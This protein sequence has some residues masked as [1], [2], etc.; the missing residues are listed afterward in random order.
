MKLRN[1]GALLLL[2]MIWGISF[3]LIR[4]AAPELGPLTLVNAR[5]LIASSVLLLYAV[6]LR[7]ARPQLRA[8]WKAYLILGALN[9]AL[10]L[11]LEAIAVVH[12]SASLA[13]MLVTTTPLFTALAAALWLGERLTLPKLIGL[14]L[15]LVGVGILVGWSPLPLSLTVG[16]AVGASLLSALFYA[17]AGI[18]AKVAFRKTPALS[19]A[20]GQAL[21]AGVVMLPLT[22]AAPPSTFPTL[23]A[24]GA[25]VTLALV[26][27]AGGNLLYFYLI[28]QIG[29]TKTQS[30]AF[31]I[32]VFALLAGA[33]LGEPLT[34]STLLG[35][36]II[37]M[38]VVL[39]T[40]V[41]LRMRRLSMPTA[42]LRRAQ[43][44]LASV[45]PLTR[46]AALPISSRPFRAWP[47]ASTPMYDRHSIRRHT[48]ERS[49]AM[50]A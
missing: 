14:V 37:L 21:L 3:L 7:Q 40:E 16:V 39:V 23:P 34:S 4:I 48:Y 24:I 49:S 1:V 8:S 6:A 29:P 2:A 32:P 19:L 31:L 11:T 30:V 26:M 33:L 12:L 25:T 41:Q 46:S 15:G 47:T 9:T 5:M 43:L 28:D 50:C 36:G 44:G 17:L 27:T 13:A 10:P 45:Q 38:S 20:I 18:Y 42:V 35:L 22:L